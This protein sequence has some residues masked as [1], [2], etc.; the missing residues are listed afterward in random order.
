MFFLISNAKKWLAWKKFTSNEEIT[1]SDEEK[2]TAILQ[3]LTNRI[4]RSKVHIYKTYVFETNN[5][6]R[7]RDQ[8]RKKQRQN[9][10]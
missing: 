3:G 1:S 9:A 6:V 5:D 7:D 8:S 10:F 2:Q 4:F